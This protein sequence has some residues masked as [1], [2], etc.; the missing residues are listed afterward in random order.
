MMFALL[1]SVASLL[2]LPLLLCCGPGPQDDGRR[3]A[4][5]ASR[6]QPQNSVPAD[7][8]G[9]KE[10]E[11]PKANTRSFPF[12]YAST[13]AI[14]VPVTVGESRAGKFVLDT[15]ASHHLLDRHYEQGLG[16]PVAIK[17]ISTAGP[18]A[19]A[20]IF[21]PPRMRLGE[22]TVRRSRPVVSFDLTVV[23]QAMG[24][25][26]RGILG[27]PFLR[28]RTIAVD[29]DGGA[30]KIRDRDVAPPA[31]WGSAVP[32]DVDSLGR[33]CIPNVLIGS[34]C[35]SFLLDTGMTGSFTLSAQDFEMLHE[36]GFIE[37]VRTSLVATL[38]GRKPRRTGLLQRVQIGPFVHESVEVAESTRN[39]IGLRYLSRYAIT[40]D[41]SG[42][43]VYLAKGASYSDPDKLDR[44]GLHLLWLNG[45]AVVDVVDPGSPAER[46][47]IES[48]DLLLEMNLKPA[49]DTPLARM[50]RVLCGEPGEKVEVTLSRDGRTLHRSFHLQKYEDW[51]HAPE[52]AAVDEE[53]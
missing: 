32:V 10:T 27:A 29:F 21:S 18:S 25:D 41:V 23:S 14:L 45:D 20:R 39:K 1:L 26:I 30:V 8:D 53:G 2:N 52:G 31:S 15:G 37:S 46:A 7:G 3:A 4:T 36:Q 49:T 22:I 24:Y 5:E 51:A 48:G 11:P 9:V 16:E 6:A 19:I 33:P 44:S 35:T 17:R 40:F 34:S 38:S 13:D 42:R 47:G 28:K 12:N 50:R 43:L